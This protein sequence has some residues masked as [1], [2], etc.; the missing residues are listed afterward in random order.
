MGKSIRWKFVLIYF[1]LVFI[2]MVVAGIFI[3]QYIQEYHFSVASKQL[4]EMSQFIL[5]QLEAYDSLSENEKQIQ[6][7][8]DGMQNV[9]IYN[10]IYIVS[11]K[12]NRIIAT[13]TE[14]EG[15]FAEEILSF[16]ILIQ[17]LN[18]TLTD[19][20]VR[21]Q[22]GSDFLRV[23]DLAVPIMHN[24]LVIGVLYLRMDLHDIFATLNKSV[25]IIVQSI[26]ISSIFVFMLVF[27][28]S[29]T[30]TGPINDISTRVAK[31]AQ[32]D[33]DQVLEVYSDDE[34]GQL[35]RAFNFLTDRLNISLREISKE[36][37]KLETIIN[38]MEDGVL[39]VD[40]YGELI[41]INPKATRLLGLDNNKL[42]LKS[43]SKQLELDLR[44]NSILK[45]YPDG[46]GSIVKELGNLYVRISFAFYEN[47]SGEKSGIIFLI[48]D[49][50][51]SQRFEMMRREFVANVSHELKTPLTSIKSYTETLLSGDV[52]DKETEKVFLGVV[53]SEAD[54]MGRL[55]RDLLQLSNFDAKRVDMEFE[56]H[57][58]VDLIKNSVLKLNMPARDKQQSIDIITNNI[59][60]LIGYFDY[61]R[62]E[63][64]ILNIISNAIKYTQN[65]GS[66]KISLDV[67]KDDNN[68]I[69]NIVV[70]DNGVGISK[71]HLERIFERFY[72]VD[73]GRSRVLGGTGLGLSI[74]REIVE[75]HSGI[76]NMTSQVG[77]GTK[78]ILSIPL[79][80]H[81]KK[82]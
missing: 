68:D 15:G 38:S 11:K 60:E 25:V 20:V 18:G 75:Y 65:G 55:V 80:P 29:Q 50:T 72:R 76:I 58:Y 70:S 27:F 28:I 78:V 35:A 73:K 47:D 56:Y 37:S 31:M 10:E 59:D 77:K 33:F 61:D 16:D 66:I 2:A 74:A 14:N 13:T 4:N 42:T 44:F 64:V 24:E 22:V 36:N 1:M 49:I 32:G 39:A 79:N 8:L 82:G 7:L 81:N 9:G 6:N 23:K 3:I 12:D 17:A 21:L 48:Q 71:K 26:A 69:V 67:K 40:K 43:I 5:P 34:I 41:H 45:L 51:E 53:N 63:Q 19:E 57:D 52:D 54:R 46:I 30:I 62:M